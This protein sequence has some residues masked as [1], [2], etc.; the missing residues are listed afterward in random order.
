MGYS[1]QTTL[2]H[3][4]P[5]VLRKKLP[6]I[7]FGSDDKER[8]SEISCLVKAGR[9]R[10]LLPRA[11]T[12][13]ID[14]PDEVVVKK[15]LWQLIAVLFPDSLLSH[16]TAV[17]FRPSPNGSVYLTARNRRVYRWPGVTLRFTNGPTA[18]ADDN[19]VF[20][21]LYVSSLKR[22]PLEN[23]GN[24]RQSDGESR[25]LSQA[26]VEEKLVGIL[27]SGGEESLNDFRDRARQIADAFGWV[28][29]FTRLN[30]LISALLTTQ[31]VDRLASRLA[32]VVATGCPYDANRVALFAKLFNELNQT[33]IVNRP[34]KTGD[35]LPRCTA[36]TTSSTSVT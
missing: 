30:E 7:V 19:P 9:L 14:L 1:N 22:A 3:K 35:T 32:I 17:E 2:V 25:A 29:A 13:L 23:L 26:A 27:N 33:P 31:R 34:E 36:T 11:Y 16:R 15:H 12:S 6:G 5:T 24:Y 21:G 4:N 8:S 20:T 10:R 18:L 28:T